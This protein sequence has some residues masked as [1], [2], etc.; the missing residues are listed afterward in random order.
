MQP[1]YSS[2]WTPRPGV[3]ASRWHFSFKDAHIARCCLGIVFSDESRICAG[4][5]GPRCVS[6]KWPCPAFPNGVQFLIPNLQ[7]L[8]RAIDQFTVFGLVQ[9]R[10][11]VSSQC[12]QLEMLMSFVFFIGHNDSDRSP[13]FFDH[14]RLTLRGVQKCPELLLRG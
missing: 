3:S 1:Q 13:F 11:Q 6:L 4:R 7:T 2:L 10:L 5:F 9:P 12:L 14:H 8:G